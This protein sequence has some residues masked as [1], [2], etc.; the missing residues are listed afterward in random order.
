MVDLPEGVFFFEIWLCVIRSFVPYYLVN[1][2][3]AIKRENRKNVRK[4]IE[5]KKIM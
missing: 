1:M 5:N 4:Y 3:V 2:S